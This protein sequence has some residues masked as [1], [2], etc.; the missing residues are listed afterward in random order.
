M[1]KDFKMT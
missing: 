1:K